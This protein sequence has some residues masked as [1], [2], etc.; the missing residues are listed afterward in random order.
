MRIVLACGAASLALATVAFAQDSA[1]VHEVVFKYRKSLS[2]IEGVID[3]TA[4]GVNGEHRVL[5]R[6]AS[7]ESKEAIEQL[8]G[9]KLEGFPIHVLVTA[10]PKPPEPAVEATTDPPRDEPV[11]A[12]RRPGPGQTVAEPRPASETKSGPRDF[13][14]PHELCDILREAQGLPARKDDGK[15]RCAWTRVTKWVSPGV[16]ERLGNGRDSKAGTACTH[17][18]SPA[19]LSALEQAYLRSRGYQAVPVKTQK[20]TKCSAG[21]A[22]KDASEPPPIAGSSGWHKGE[23]VGTTFSTVVARHRKL[24]PLRIAELASQ[25]FRGLTP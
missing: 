19:E 24:C 22:G 16:V 12:P 9:K 21:G 6:V 5:I 10:A 23:G 18:A 3:V 8:L 14:D 25:V 17:V 1:N 4:A 15:G 20:C 2:K 13:G 11:V 7:R